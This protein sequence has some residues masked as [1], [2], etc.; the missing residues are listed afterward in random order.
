MVSV[1]R[2]SLAASVWLRCFRAVLHYRTMRGLD[3]G[4]AQRLTGRRRSHAD[5]S[6]DT[7][8]KMG[9]LRS[10]FRGLRGNE[11]P[12]VSANTGSTIQARLSRMSQKKASAPN[13]GRSLACISTGHPRGPPSTHMSTTLRKKREAGASIRYRLLITGPFSAGSLAAVPCLS[14][15]GQLAVAVLCLH[16]G[17]ELLDYRL[18]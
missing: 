10:G 6:G 9:A 15:R 2:Y 14:A 3:E 16:G 8:T 7:N 13:Q 11:F 1:N 4:T 5:R 17:G 18:Q 12:K